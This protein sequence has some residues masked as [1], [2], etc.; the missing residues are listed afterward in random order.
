MVSPRPVATP[1]VANWNPLARATSPTTMM[2][3][4]TSTS[5]SV[6]PRSFVGFDTFMMFIARSPVPSS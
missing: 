3:V 2:K 4:A 1:L 6:K 5:A